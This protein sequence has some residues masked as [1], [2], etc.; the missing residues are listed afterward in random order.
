LGGGVGQKEHTDAIFAGWWQFDPAFLGYEFQKL[1]RRLDE[2]TGAITGVGFAT[3]STAVIQ[4]EQ[5][6][7][8]LLNDCVRLATFDV[9]HEPDPAGFMLEL[10]VVQPLRCW[11][12]GS[13][14]L[15]AI[16]CHI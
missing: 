9:Y 4:V 2:N 13:P 7:K 15:T 16:I 11:W 3:A 8:G 10:R 6:L 1:M 5:N 12:P 14:N